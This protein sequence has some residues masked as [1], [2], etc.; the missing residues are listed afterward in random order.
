MKT[1]KLV[2]IAKTIRSK[3]AGTDRITFDIIFREKEN[4]ELVKASK[5][6]T[7]EF[8]A[9]LFQICESRISDFVEFDPAYA[10]KFTILRLQPSGSP[11]EGDVFGCQQYPP[12]L[13][14]EIPV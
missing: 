7:K 10:I 13:D 12:L 3:N 11:G 1:I 4:Y 5:I 8:I 2:D 6:I 14:I 9:N